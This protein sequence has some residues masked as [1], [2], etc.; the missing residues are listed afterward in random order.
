MI[1][2]EPARQ[3]CI[4]QSAFFGSIYFVHVDKNLKCSH[5]RTDIEKGKSYALTSRAFC[6]NVELKLTKLLKGI[7]FLFASRFFC[8]SKTEI[9]YV[10][11]ILNLFFTII[12][13]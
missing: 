1:F 9:I 12:N 8:A 5:N 7:G 10:V 11:N 3:Q 2:L 6:L 13:I 4:L